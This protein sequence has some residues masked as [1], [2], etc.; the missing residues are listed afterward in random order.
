MSFIDEL[1]LQVAS[2]PRFHQELESL[3]AANL[4][5]GLPADTQPQQEE[6]QTVGE[7]DDESL[8]RI[9]QAASI[10]ASSNVP[11]L[12]TL[13]QSI[14][15]AALRLAGEDREVIESLFATIQARLNN[16]P[17]L[18][19]SPSGAVA[20]GFAPLSIQYEFVRG[21]DAQTVK[22]GD[23]RLHILSSFQLA[24]W[25]V[26]SSSVSTTLSAPTSA[27]KSYVLLLFLA[28]AFRSERVRRAV[29]VVP[30]RALI[31]Q[32]SGDVERVLE[33]AG[34]SRVEIVS[35]PVDLGTDRPV[36]YVLTQERLEALLTA[37]PDIRF[38][39]VLI[40]EAQVL[41]LGARGVL[42]ES[43]I[44]RILATSQP[45]LVFVGP[46]IENPEYFGAAFELENFQP[47]E[48]SE[49][50][51]T[52]NILYLN[53][54]PQ[55]LS[56]VRVCVGGTSRQSIGFDI[57]IELRLHADTDK[58]SF[59]SYK[60]GRSGSSLVYCNGKA[61]AEKVA[62]A[63]ASQVPGELDDPDVSELIRFVRKHVHPEYALVATLA[64]GVAFHYG[65]MPSLL[66]QEIER[67]FKG[68][69]L[70]FLACTSTLLYGLNLPAKNL[71]LLKPTTGRGVPISGP[72][73]WNLA[74]RVGRLGKELE[75][76]VYLIDYDSWS[77]SP[78]G[79]P[80]SV[81]IQSAV[82]QWVVDRTEAFLDFA[83]NELLASEQQPELETA[84]GKLLVDYRNGRLDATL[85]RYETPQNEALLRRVAEKVAAISDDVG[86]PFDVMDANI[87]VSPFR[88][89]ELLEYMRSGLKRMPPA[90]LVPAHPLGDF[91]AV[92]ANY[93]R[94][95][96]RI[97]NCLLGTAKSNRS[98]LYFA[99]LALRWM[100]GDSLP[101]LISS[102]IK[103]HREK[104]QSVST[105]AIIRSVM[106]NIEE[107]LR[108]RYVKFFRAYRAVLEVALRDAGLHDHVEGI[109]DIPLFLEM[110]GSSGAMINLMALGLSRTSAEAL[111]EYLL[112]KEMDLRELRIW[113]AGLELIGL[114]LSPV[115][116]REVEETRER[117]RTA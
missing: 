3:K 5:L 20:P 85:G 79:E 12:R 78:V 41:A 35:I 11:S 54:S 59:L 40:D 52:Q 115:V 15:T 102:A 19:L 62:I 101:V 4:A 72:D 39:L 31:N 9:L 67:C 60:F 48:T 46:M 6:S 21:R 22:T 68:K 27:G 111:S 61:E 82:K 73:F 117:I 107:D 81:R 32:V 76:N 17:A 10:F 45:Q 87:G 44:D 66:R 114:D 103:F 43:V 57:P 105:A 23:D 109:P 42:L 90:E 113:L 106:E 50:P 16:Y 30:T 96:K 71:F 98:H 1:A 47:R 77:S 26:L 91:K 49:S 24:C 92:L 2:H 84:L 14:S 70:P 53:Y 28:E 95:F 13:A 38:D 8:A 112:D 64:K 93:Y 94:V 69:R 63:I 83:S 51:V 86:L 80:K 110:G 99:P 100:R 37:S 58:L 18:A 36:F 88:M 55:P 104:A 7:L 74:G 116:L 75:G 34:T 33:E 108:F 89:R 56:S 65:H 29:Y 97:H 25:R